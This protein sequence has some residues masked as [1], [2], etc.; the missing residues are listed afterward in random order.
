MIIQKIAY[1]LGI[2]LFLSTLDRVS[3]SFAAKTMNVEMGFNPEIYGFGVGLFFITYMLFQMPGVILAKRKGPAWTLAMMTVMWGIVTV[4]TGFMWNKNS[5]Y[6]FRLLLGMMEGSIAPVLVLYISRWVPTSVFGRFQ[7]RSSLALPA[8]F[9]LGGPISGW[10]ITQFGDLG[11]LAGWR[12]MFIIEGLAT[13]LVGIL[14]FRLLPERIED[15]KWLNAEDGAWLVQA[16]ARGADAPPSHG[17]KSPY[18]GN[19]KPG[20]MLLSW[21]AIFFCLCMGF[22]GFMYWLPQVIQMLA[23]DSSSLQLM[24]LSAVP[25]CAATIGMLA[26]G[27]L[28]DRTIHR[29]LHVGGATF[30]AA[31]GLLIAGVAPNPIVAFAGLVICGLGIGGSQTLFFSIPADKLRGRPSAGF[32]FACITLAGGLSGLV[33]ANLIGVMRQA[34]GSFTSAIFMLATV[35]MIGCLIM[36]VS[37]RGEGRSRR[38]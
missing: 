7:S 5:F 37:G 16:L 30:I 33:G 27:K 25:W 24:G 26:N 18:L 12:W 14:A 9:I 15:A 32:A 21:S 34:T 38:C 11:G 17:A 28:L 6:I 19:L 3:V 29:S 36:I 22:Y 23:P 20:L 13:I 2:I 35:Y 10:L 1:F 4:A 8:S 31:A